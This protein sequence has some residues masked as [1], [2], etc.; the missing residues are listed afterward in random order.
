[1][2]I[3]GIG[4]QV[5]GRLRSLTASCDESDD[6]NPAIA[7]IALLVWLQGPVFVLKLLVRP[8]VLLA[9]LV[10]NALVFAFH[11]HCA[12]DAYRGARRPAFPLRAIASGVQAGRVAVVVGLL[13][14][15]AI[16]HVAAGYY[17]YRNYDLITSVFADDEPASPF[18]TAAT[19]PPPGTIFSV[20]A[21]SVSLLSSFVNSSVWRSESKIDS[22][23][24]VRS[25][26]WLRK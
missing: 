22:I 12:V 2:A 6:T 5:L 8:D 14:L 9:L 4:I 16:P 17:G 19:L 3:G 20:S 7:S 13:A 15:V 18:L 26:A 21:T 23:E 25:A 11:A 10:A 24:A 1:V